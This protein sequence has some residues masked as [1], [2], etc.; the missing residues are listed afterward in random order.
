MKVL[1]VVKVKKY[2]YLSKTLNS[3]PFIILAGRENDNGRSGYGNLVEG[4]RK[5]RY[6]KF[7]NKLT[8]KLIY[9]SM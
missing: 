1:F 9:H 6:S 2:C 7:L 5:P 4:Q 8:F 3:F